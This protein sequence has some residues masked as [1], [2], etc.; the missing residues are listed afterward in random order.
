MSNS[1]TTQQDPDKKKKKPWNSKLAKSLLKG[2]WWFFIAA[3]VCMVI[4]SAAA[5]VS[6]LVIRMTVDSIL[7]NEPMQ[8]PEWILSLITQVGGRD[9]L[10]RNLWIFSL[11]ILVL[12]LLNSAF[13]FLRGRAAAQGSEE[14][15][16]DLRDRMY[17]HFQHLSFEYHVKV[18]TGDL[19]QRCSSDVETVRRFLAVQVVEIGRII[20]STVLGISIMITLNVQ[21]TLISLIMIPVLMVI[22]AFYFK[23]MQTTFL[24]TDEAEGALSNTV[25]ESLTGIRVVRAFGQQRQEMDKFDRRNQVFSDAVVRINRLMGYFWGMTDILIYIQ[26][27]VIM[28][29]GTLFV[30]EGRLSVG[31]LIAF[32]SYAGMLLWPC[33]QLGRILADMGKATVALDRIGE[34]LDTPAEPTDGLSPEQPLHGD[35]VFDHVTFNYDGTKNVLEDV[36]FTVKQGQTVAILGG[37][38]SGKS[39]M[40]YLLQRLYD[41]TGGRITIGG[42]DIREFNRKWLRGQVGIVL[43]EPFLYSRSIAQNIAITRPGAPAEEVEEVTRISA[44]SDVIKEFDSG[45]DTVVG[46]RGVTLSGGQKQ[47]VAIARMLIRNTPVLIFDD[48]LSAVDTQ[49]DQIIRRELKKRRAGATTFIISH[50]VTTLAEADFILVMENGRL[51]E[52]GTHQELSQRPGLY[53]RVWN[54][55][56]ALGEEMEEDVRQ[57]DAGMKGEMAFES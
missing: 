49:T 16:K 44:L 32:S 46:E 56:S 34:V 48:S 52:Q 27:A 1:K 15:A 12:A 33:R 28:I 39:T 26:Q 20:S 37:T 23:R 14:V 24:K 8:A 11:L 51:V 40:M 53:Q 41:V 17:T 5:Y 3:F 47:R 19:L 35:I 18:E 50:R 2:R 6:P 43:Q 45:Y 57:T 13:A 31:T 54:I 38:G 30:L 21:L 7:G 36:S 4:S 55:Q 25:Q 9:V 10:V 22:S 29:T 42:R